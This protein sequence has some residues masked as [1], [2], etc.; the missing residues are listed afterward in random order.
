MFSV[1]AY[2]YIL[3]TYVDIWPIVLKRQSIRRRVYMWCVM[4]WCA[5]QFVIHYSD[6]IMGADEFQ[7]TGVS[8]VYLTICSGAGQRNTKAPRHWP[9][10]GE[11][12]GDRWIP[13]TM[14]QLRGKCFYLMTSSS[15]REAAVYIPQT[16]WYI[17]YQSS[18][19]NSNDSS[20]SS[21]CHQ[22][23]SKVYCKWIAQGSFLLG[24]ND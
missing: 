22:Q 2:I 9:L 13:R 23:P 10:W 18:R 3:L 19:N 6:V 16:D 7:I 5:L 11:F 15:H 1:D 8:I 17:F 20:A 4:W 21:Q 12:T 14:G 24:S